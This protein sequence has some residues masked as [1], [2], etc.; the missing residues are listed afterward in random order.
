MMRCRRFA[1]MR[2]RSVP[3]S[4]GEKDS[5]RRTRMRRPAG[6]GPIAA[7]N[8]TLQRRGVHR[9]KRSR[10]VVRRGCA[11][12][13]QLCRLP[14]SR[15]RERAA[16]ACTC[17]VPLRYQTSGGS[18]PCR[19]CQCNA[20]ASARALAKGSQRGERRASFRKSDPMQASSSSAEKHENNKTV[21]SDIF[22]TSLS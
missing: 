17:V 20:I 18:R 5:V 2:A 1:T 7:A 11:S 6:C 13:G 4:G 22:D 3:R 16:F 10:H 12:A 15:K 19:A 14:M 8:R 9:A 21:T